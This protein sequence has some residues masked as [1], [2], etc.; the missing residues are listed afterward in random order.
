MRI[1]LLGLFLFSAC[2]KGTATVGQQPAKRDAQVVVADADPSKLEGKA[3]YTTLCAHCHGPN[4]EGYKSDNAP[5][6]K[7]PTF[8]ESA[9]DDFL[10]RSINA[11][12]P[13]T[14]MAGYGHA[15]GGPLDDAAVARLVGYIRSQG[16]QAK[17]LP[18]TPST[19]DPVKGQIIYARDC[20][21]C[22]G[23][24]TVRMTA[25]HLAN[26]RFLEMAS[27]E[28][29]RYAIVNGRPGTP[30]EAFAAK[31]QPVE[32]EHVVAYIRSFSKPQQ[33]GSLPAPTGKE[34]LVINPTGKEPQFKNMRSDPGQTLPRYVSVDEVKKALDEKRKLIIIDARPAS[35]WMQV[36]ITGA[37]SIPY[38]DMKRLDDM[39]KDVYAIAYCA[40]P[41]HL[42][43]V[44]VDE[45]L[46]RGY[47]KALVLDEG[48]LEWHR[49]GYPV[50]A[51][52]GVMPPPK[53][54][55]IVPINP[56]APGQVPKKK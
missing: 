5:S 46:K 55:Q 15:I 24:P 27:D 45:L 38:H 7:N 11:G 16:P 49:R 8:L 50:V 13:G 9:T 23:D 43:G 18:P 4:L 33:I 48:I 53:E 1:A 3:L 17:P 44:V 35:D 37:V 34:P 54:E 56:V 6:L 21:K 2:S 30:M 22:H 26:M 47:K 19:G 14:S 29:I 12:R 32:I 31:L 52:P 10:T 25:V 51:A 42:S 41:H 40:C 39:P 20:Q 36:H 28:F